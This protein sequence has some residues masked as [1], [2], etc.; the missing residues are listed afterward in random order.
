[1]YRYGDGTPF[2]LDENFIE[3][4]TTAVETCTNAFM[5]LTELDNRRERAKDARKAADRENARLVEFEKALTEAL[6]PW[7]Q[8]QQKAD[9][10]QQIAQKVGM[11]AKQTLSQTRQAI[12]ARVSAMEAQAAPR[13]ASDA[14][15]QA[16][17]PFFD[18][19]QLPKT[20]WIMSWDVRG[21]EPQANA[22]STSGR[23]VATYELQADPYRLPIRVDQL[24]DGI[25]VHM[26][27]K[28]M[29]GKAKPAPIEL[30]KYVLVSFER[31]HGEHVLTLRE[32][33]AKATAGIRF[34]VGDKEKDATWVAILP[35]GDADGEPNPLDFE[36]V[37]GVRRL[38]ERANAALK[39]LIQRRHLV[40]LTLAG[41]RLDDMPE[42][43]VVPLEIL[44]QLTP[45][46]RT[47]R[48]RSR[49]TGELVLKRDIGDGRRE[50]LY[51]PRSSLAQQFAKLP[52]EYRRPFEDMGISSEDT[53]P[54]IQL[55]RPPAK[56]ASTQQPVVAGP[57]QKTIE[58]KPE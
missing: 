12:D 43:R 15:L 4:L 13:T 55:P 58:I 51:V 24:A 16:L 8:G 2:P 6:T 30:G 56:P 40:D 32:S 53:Q 39:D 44:T 25:V 37:E 49:M 47:I 22:V 41:E 7:L 36:D 45:L 19:N 5:P 9:S 42:P 52:A 14:V 33:A 1:M 54:A 38:G 11:A 10:T 34:A 18:A 28:G 26:M 57:D 50:E 46:A 35:S 21:N 3:T 17:K 31:T 29:F 20:T 23:L 48:E 27:K